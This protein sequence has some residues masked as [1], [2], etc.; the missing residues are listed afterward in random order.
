M[1]RMNLTRASL[2][3]VKSYRH[4]FCPSYNSGKHPKHK[5]R[6]VSVPGARKSAAGQKVLPASLSRSLESAEG[7]TC[8]HL[9]EREQRSISDAR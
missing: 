8:S 1:P 9:A 5:S 2:G 4:D 3:I 6:A 7:R